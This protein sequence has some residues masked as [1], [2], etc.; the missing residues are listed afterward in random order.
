MYSSSVNSFSC[1][2]WR[3]WF[4]QAD[5]SQVRFPTGSL[6]F[7]IDL[8]IPAALWLWGR[9]SLSHT[10]APETSPGGKGGRW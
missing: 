8:T 9:L 5:R 1:K 10:R 4:R 7:Y 2:R 6:E 3:S